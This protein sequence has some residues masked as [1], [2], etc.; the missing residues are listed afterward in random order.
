MKTE[1][2]PAWCKL[3][4]TPWKIIRGLFEPDGYCCVCIG[5]GAGHR[6][7]RITKPINPPVKINYLKYP[8]SPCFREP[9]LPPPCVI[10]GDV[11]IETW[12]K[13]GCT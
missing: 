6:N 9:L 12:I 1:L 8:P 11:S 5:C 4:G 2:K 7:R 13:N 3:C 10:R